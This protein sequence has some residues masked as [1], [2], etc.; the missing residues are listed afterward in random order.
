MIILFPDLSHP[1]ECLSVAFINLTEYQV[2]GSWFLSSF[3]DIDIC[4][5]LESIAGE[6]SESNLHF[7]HV[8]YGLN[9]CPLP[10]SRGNV[11]AIAIV[12]RSATFRR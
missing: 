12:L 7:F 4:L 8:C 10:N 9:V 3:L 2:T 1:W 11:I 6:K 5:L